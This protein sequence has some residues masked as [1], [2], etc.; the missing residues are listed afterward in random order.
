MSRKAQERRRKIFEVLSSHTQ[1]EPILQGK[2]I[3]RLIGAEDLTVKTIYEDMRMLRGRR[4]L[5]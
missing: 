1:A 2:Q 4:G 5:A 3:L